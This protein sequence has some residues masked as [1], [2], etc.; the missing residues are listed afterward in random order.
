MVD[1]LS[2]L[3]VSFLYFEDATT[4]MHVGS[5]AIFQ[6]EGGAHAFDYEALVQLIEDRIALVPRYRQVVH[7]VPGNLAS[8]VWV[9]DAAFD[10][11]YHV[12]RSALP[13]PGTGA[14]L[15]DFVARVMSRPLDKARPLWEM[16]LVEGLEDGQFA[17]LT[18]THHAMVDGIGAVEIGQVIL[19][20]TP[21]PRVVPLDTWTPEPAPSDVSL[22]ADAIGELVHRPTAV[23]D[24]ARRAVTDVSRTVGRVGGV[25]SVARTMAR[26]APS[27]PL[28]VADRGAASVRAGRHVARRLPQGAQGPRRDGQRRRAGGRQRR[29]ADMAAHPG[30]GGPREHRGP[31]DGAGQRAS[32]GR[33]RRERWQPDRLAARRPPRRGEQSGRPAAPRQLCHAGPQ[34]VR[35]VGRRP[36]ARGDRRLRAADACT[37]S[38]PGSLRTFRAGCST[39]SSPTSPGRSVRCTPEA[40]ASSRRTPSSP[41]TGPGTDDRRHVL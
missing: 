25:L 23:I 15:D 41:R 20:I 37:R 40:P 34:G 27:S 36:G 31:R 30:R 28:N 39:S 18:K 8:P 12:R 17:V 9:D 2:A 26:Q 6:P 29:P 4:P 21:E 33:Q 38:A 22:L 19:D 35:S 14:Q 32:S 1:R 10:V 16:Y 24:L 3:D 11:T 5:V 7:K 13:R